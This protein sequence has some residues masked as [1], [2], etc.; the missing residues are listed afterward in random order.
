MHVDTMVFVDLGD[1]FRDN[2]VKGTENSFVSDDEMSFRVQGMEDASKLDTN[3][4]STNNS[5]ALWLL[6]ELKKPSEVIP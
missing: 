3:V 2:S 6:L 1:I 5:N 4:T